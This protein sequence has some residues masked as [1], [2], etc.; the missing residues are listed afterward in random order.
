MEKYA[1]F[2]RYEY[3]SI[4][5][6]TWTKWFRMFGSPITDNEK[7]LYGDLKRIKD[8]GKDIDKKTHLKNEYEIQ[9]FNYEPIN[10]SDLKNLPKAERKKRKTKK[11]EK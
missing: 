3:H 7:E 9:K 10:I 8:I 5:G 6:I 1:V 4:S 11:T 2:Q